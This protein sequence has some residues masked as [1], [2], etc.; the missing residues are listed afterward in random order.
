MKK[1]VYISLGALFVSTGIIGIFIPLLPTTIFLIIA[2]YF[3]MNSSP[4][5]NEKLLNNKYLGKYIR[6]YKENRGMPFKA[7]VKSISL[8]WISILASGYFFTDSFVIR[9]ILLVIAI[10]VSI[11]ISALK[12][13]QPRIISEQ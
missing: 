10:G 2:S 6:D 7:K 5:L 8:L 9:I 12:T 3:F 13:L 4:E 11:H 1:I